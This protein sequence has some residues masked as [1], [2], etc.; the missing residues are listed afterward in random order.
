MAQ[1]NFLGGLC[2]ELDSF[3]CECVPVG[4]GCRKW[5][6]RLLCPN[7]AKVFLR[8]CRRKELV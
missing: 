2:P 1:I 5:S 6:V 8:R 4:L 3:F 7:L